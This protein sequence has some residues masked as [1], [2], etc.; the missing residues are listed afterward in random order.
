MA[1]WPKLKWDVEPTGPL[2]GIKVV[3]MAT[4]VL[5]PFATL[6]LADLGAEVIKIE[7]SEGNT[8]GDLMRYAGDS[9]T[10]DLGPIFAALNRNKKAMNLNVKT[11][12][13]KAILSALLEDADVFI[14][15]VRMAGMERLGFGYE[16]VKAINPDIIYVH[17]AGFGADGEYGE[18]QAYDDLIQA[19][20][21]FA[22]L[23][24]MRD[25]GRP[26]YAP[27]LVAD[28]VSGLFAAQAV[29]AAIIARHNG[30]G[31]QF[32]Q[33]PMFEVFTW[34]HMVENLFG[35]TFLPGNGKL[36]YT[37][38]INPRRRPYP[39]ADGYIAIVPYNDNQWRQFFE[40]G[41]RPGVFDDP[42]F[43]TYQ[44]RANNVGDL[45][46]IIEEV[47]ATKTTDEWVAIL[48]DHNIPAMRYQ[49]MDDVIADPHLQQVGFF[50]LR[51]GE[52]MGRYRSMRHPVLY[53]GT[54]VTTY[55]NPP[56]PDAD[57]EEIRAALG[58]KD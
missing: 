28:K 58:F 37:R 30:Q 43:S 11:D 5:G 46:A 41:G 12:N 16:A 8:P 29:M 24:E 49:R 21:G 55:A 31:G 10:K 22:S 27:S 4:V 1:K 2:K 18:R 47:A 15:N 7:N 53:T 33:M 51:E 54:P 48:D 44:E 20:S 50:E 45:Y 13:G 6:Q 19:A 14:H 9:P 25:G 35:E 26:S 23:S 57:G 34:F 17:C 42:R 52:H 32:V 40:L 3:D 38:S 36:A 56:R 39:T